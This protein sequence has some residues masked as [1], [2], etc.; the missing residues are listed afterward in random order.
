MR[1]L[2]LSVG[3]FVPGSWVYII[4]IAGQVAPD[5]KCGSALR[6]WQLKK[7]AMVVLALAISVLA[8]SHPALAHHSSASFDLDHEVTFKGTVANFEWS[9]PHT[10]N[11]LD[12]KDEKGNVEQWRVEGNS[13]NML[14]RVGWKREMLKPG[15]QVTAIGH[16]PKT[17]ARV[18]RLKSLVFPNGQKYDGEALKF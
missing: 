13:P 16:L 15:D 17:G 4:H 1:T 11:Y 3:D 18:M 7:H 6:R 2:A 8:G 9:N 12:V 14:S 5:A 10:F